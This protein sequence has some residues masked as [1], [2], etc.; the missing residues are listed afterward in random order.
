MLFRGLRSKILFGIARRKA[1][2]LP[3]RVPCSL[4]EASSIGI[5]FDAQEQKDR[6]AVLAFHEQLKE[7]QKDVQLLGF[8]KKRDLQVVYH[9]PYLTPRDV[10]WYGKPKGGTAG[11]FIKYPF[12]LLINLCTHELLP[13]EYISS[14][15]RAKFRIGALGKGSMEHYDYLIGGVEEEEQQRMIDNIERY[16]K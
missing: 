9:F 10:T 4:Q 15:S 11:Y 16:L 5:L 12:N 14:V 13:F 1:V 7:Q 3:D 2:A 8:V 6:D